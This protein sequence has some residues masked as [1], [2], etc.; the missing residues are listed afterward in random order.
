ML[1]DNFECKIV[2]YTERTI[3]TRH[4]PYLDGNVHYLTHNHTTTHNLIQ[5]TNFGE[6]AVIAQVDNVFEPF[7]IEL[8]FSQRPQLDTD[9]VRQINDFQKS[10]QNLVVQTGV[11]SF[12]DGLIT[13]YNPTIAN[14]SHC[15]FNKY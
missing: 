12:I 6:M 2:E 5:Y 13:L 8:L 10:G 1:A 15:P 9:F 11:Y 4:H 14:F 7:T 3:R